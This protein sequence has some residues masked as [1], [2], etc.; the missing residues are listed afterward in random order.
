MVFSGVEF[1]KR[2]N[3][4]TGAQAGDPATSSCPTHLAFKYPDFVMSQTPSHFVSAE[5]VLQNL[6]F[7]PFRQ[8]CFLKQPPSFLV[9]AE[10]PVNPDLVLAFRQAGPLPNLAR[11]SSS[12]KAAHTYDS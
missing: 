12:P 1:C 6:D 7:T 2:A 8:V 5:A 4:S 11:S 3:K 10:P 9:S